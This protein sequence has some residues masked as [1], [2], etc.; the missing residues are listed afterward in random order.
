MNWLVRFVMV[1]L[2]VRQLWTHWFSGKLNIVKNH[3][4]C[5]YYSVTHNFKT[6]QHNKS[7]ILSKLHTPASSSTDLYFAIL[8]NIFCL[9]VFNPTWL[10]CDLK[11]QPIKSHNFSWQ[12]WEAGR[13]KK[14]ANLWLWWKQN[15]TKF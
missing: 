6:K 15:L 1:N 10:A 2:S 4:W 8:H 7:I 9:F 12:A 11:L 3:I 5:S 13:F 14:H